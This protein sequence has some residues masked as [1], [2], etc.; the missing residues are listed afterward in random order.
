MDSN[1]KKSNKNKKKNKNINK[2]ANSGVSVNSDHQL[3][4]VNQ[5]LNYM[6][7]DIRYLNR[8]M[9]DFIIKKTQ[10]N[11]ENNSGVEKQLIEIKNSLNE[12]IDICLYE[13]EEA[14]KEDEEENTKDKKNIVMIDYDLDLNKLQ[15]EDIIKGMDIPQKLFSPFEH[16]LDLFNKKRIAP[17]PEVKE[18]EQDNFVNIDPNIK[19]EELNIEVKSIDDLIELGNLY[20]KLKGEMTTNKVQ[21]AS[22]NN[23]NNNGLYELNGKYYSV[24]LEILNKLIVP[25][26]KLNSMIG[27]KNVKDSIVEMILYYMQKFEKKNKNMLHTIIEGPPGTGKTEIGI[28]LA[29]IYACMGITKSNKFKKV[30]RTELIGEFVGHS[31]HRTQRVIDEADGGVLFIDEAYSLGSSDGKDSFSKECIDILNLNLSENKDNFI[32]IIA[33]YKDELETCFFKYNPGLSRRF[34][35]KYTI[36]GYSHE[37]L[38]DIFSKKVLDIKWKLDNGVDVNK[39]FKEHMNDFQ[40]YGGDIDNLILFCRFCHSRRVFSKNPNIRMILNNKDMENGFKKFM[41]NKAGGG[42]IDKEK[43]NMFI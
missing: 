24:N 14:D 12:L 9:I 43:L 18:E 42:K 13:E 34:P 28:I 30:K 19:I 40:N 22:Q 37:E 31:A 21:V 7:E 27:L 10:D 4:M 5:Q 29:E 23:N 39:F 6:R 35:F 1:Q 32:C 16:L 41:D 3:N 20:V 38:R 25:L 33:G 15:K 8:M 2:N 11:A 36:D 17:V 26:Q